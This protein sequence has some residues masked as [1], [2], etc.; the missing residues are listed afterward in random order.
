MELRRQLN[1]NSS[2]PA[3]IKD[4]CAQYGVSARR[5]YQD[6]RRLTGGSVQNYVTRK[7]LEAATIL[8]TTTDEKVEWIASEVGWESRKNLNRALARH[9]GSSPRQVRRTH[10]ERRSAT[11]AASH[12]A[13]TDRSSTRRKVRRKRDRPL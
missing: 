6:F 2:R 1:G 4:F 8:L 13:A 5:I 3:L 7:R 11:V 10:L 12:T 9:H